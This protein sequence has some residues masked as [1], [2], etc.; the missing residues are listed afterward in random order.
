M[1]ST[2]LKFENR[3]VSLI[4]YLKTLSSTFVKFQRLTVNCT[5][6]YPHFILIYRMIYLYIGVRSFQIHLSSAVN[7]T[8][9]DSFRSSIYMKIDCLMFVLSLPSGSVAIFYLAYA[10]NVIPSLVRPPENPL[11]TEHISS[12]WP[13]GITSFLYYSRVVFSVG[14][15][16]RL[17]RTSILLFRSISLSTFIIHNC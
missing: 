13:T 1:S 8:V 12:V 7:C 6:D 4:C 16:T 17:D 3:N 5:L 9:S 10:V 11:I 2:F 14:L 15:P